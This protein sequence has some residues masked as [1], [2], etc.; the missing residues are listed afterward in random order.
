[1]ANIIA[2]LIIHFCGSFSC[3]KMQGKQNPK[4][5]G[6]VVL[7]S[8]LCYCSHFLNGALRHSR[9][10][11]GGNDIQLE[12]QAVPLSPVT[13]LHIMSTFRKQFSLYHFLVVVTL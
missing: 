12:P 9:R 8:V 11:L 5:P 3:L 10:V 2:V 4:E 7:L 6:S 1:M 13:A